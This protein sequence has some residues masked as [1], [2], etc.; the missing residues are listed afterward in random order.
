MSKVRNYTL[1]FSKKKLKE[2]IMAQLRNAKA[3]KDEVEAQLIAKYLG[4]A[5]EENAGE[6]EAVKYLDQGYQGNYLRRRALVDQ[7]L[8][9]NKKADFSYADK[10][11]RFFGEHGTFAS[12]DLE[13]WFRVYNQ[14]QIDRQKKLKNNV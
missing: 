13:A 9:S 5:A 1:D 12:T 7:M 4:L 10:K 11:R 6:E 14:T 3:P 2:E 8:L